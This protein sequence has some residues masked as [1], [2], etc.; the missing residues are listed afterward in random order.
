MYAN[1]ET[2]ASES[3]I[4]CVWVTSGDCLATPGLFD[5]EDIALGESP[6]MI[7]VNS[8][9]NLGST[10]AYGLN[11]GELT[12]TSDADDRTANTANSVKAAGK[13]TN[14]SINSGAHSVGVAGSVA[15]SPFIQSIRGNQ[16]N[17]NNFGNN[18][19]FGNFGISGSSGSHQSNNIREWRHPSI[20]SL[21]EI[22]RSALRGTEDCLKHTS[23][24]AIT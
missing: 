11:S 7:N 4:G 12:V 9:Y 16:A 6:M 8:R 18:G 24:I 2:I 5:F 17:Y 23:H 20:P 21:L 1:D 19:N 10:G 14:V 15:A 13:V 22:L 3:S